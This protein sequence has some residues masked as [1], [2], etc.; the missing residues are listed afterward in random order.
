MAMGKGVL[1]P[2]SSYTFSKF[3]ELKIPVD[4][5]A[6]SFG[7]ELTKQKLNLPFYAD[8]LSRLGELKLRIEE[9]LPY[10]VLF[11]TDRPA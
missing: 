5:L 3:F 8:N 11:G 6:E 4:E 1:N 9:V 10:V 2:E 7:Y